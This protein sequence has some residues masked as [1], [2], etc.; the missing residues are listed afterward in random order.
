MLWLL[1]LLG[2]VRLLG[3][4]TAIATVLPATA[5]WLVRL[6]TGVVWLLLLLP[7]PCVRVVLP[8]LRQLLL[9]L[10]LARDEWL[11][12][13]WAELVCARVE[14]PLLIS[15]HAVRYEGE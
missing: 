13:T 15:R 2:V 6:L 9:L 4:S 7:V 11:L 12:T 3:S 14:A 5:I 1:L 10:L 8:V